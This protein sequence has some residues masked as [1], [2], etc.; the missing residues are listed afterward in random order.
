MKFL[1]STLAIGALVLSVMTFDFDK[2]E[3]KGT[4]FSKHV[5]HCPI[6]SD[7]RRNLYECSVARNFKEGND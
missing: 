7:N 2:F 3:P 5:E 1:L 6:C 4:A